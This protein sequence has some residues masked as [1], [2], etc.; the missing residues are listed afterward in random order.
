[1]PSGSVSWSATPR[2]RL[3]RRRRRA[4]EFTTWS[5]DDLRDFFAGV[6]EERIFP[7][8][9]VL[10]TTGMRRGEVLG[11]RWQD[12]DLDAGQLAIVQTLTTINGVPTFGAAKS[13]RSRRIVYLDPQTVRRAARA[14]PASARGAADRRTGV[15]GDARPGVPRRGRRA[16]AADLCHEDSSARS[17]RRR[18]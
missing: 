3:G 4:S 12:V 13:S 7:A 18:A 1:M 17:S 15:D 2:R 16:T 11:L 10:A 9:V 6:R 8:L 5:S 14:P